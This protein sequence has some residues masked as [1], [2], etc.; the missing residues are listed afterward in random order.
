M[1]KDRRLDQA[2]LCVSD[3]GYGCRRFEI[4]PEGGFRWAL[5]LIR[6]RRHVGVPCRTRKLWIRCQPPTVNTN[7]PNFS[8]T[9]GPERGRF[10]HEANQRLVRQAVPG[11]LGGFRWQLLRFRLAGLRRSPREEKLWC[12]SRDGFS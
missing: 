2:A 10:L 6:D 4:L 9:E 8:N 5:R 7:S 11:P 3:M 1:L 12:V